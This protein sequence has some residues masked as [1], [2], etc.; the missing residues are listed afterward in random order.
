MLP[1]FAGLPASP[2][3]QLLVGIVALAVVVL[4]A[5]VLLSVAWK[6]LLVAGVVVAALYAVNL[7]AL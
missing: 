2:L 4:V 3:G 6:I 5:R 7:L 1:L